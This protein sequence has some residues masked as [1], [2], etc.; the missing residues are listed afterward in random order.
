MFN[1]SSYLDMCLRITRNSFSINAL[2]HLSQLPLVIDYSDETWTMTRK[3]EDNIHLGLQQHGRIC[4][5]DLHAPSSSLRMWLG[6]MNQ[7]F[8]RLIDLCL[9]S[10]TTEGKSLVLPETLQ[11]PDLRYLTLQGI[12][13]P[14]GFPLLSS[15]ITLSTLSLTYIDASSYFSPG[16]LVTHLR[17]QPHLEKLSIGFA[18]PIPCPSSERELLHPP[19]APVTLP[20]LRTLKFRGLGAYLDNLVAQI[21]TPLL[22]RLD[23][24]LFFELAFTLV[25]LTKFIQRTEGFKCLVSQVTFNKGDVSINAG[26]DEQPGIQKFSLRVKC[27]CL[28]WQID[29]ATQVC[30]ALG[31]VVSAAEELTLDLNADG[32]ISNW[33][34]TLDNMMWHELLFPF[35]GVKSLHI[36]SSLTLELSQALGSF[37][38]EL[39]PELLP[40][41][42]QIRVHLSID[43]AK[44]AFSALV[45]TRESVGRPIHLVIEDDR[46]SSVRGTLSGRQA[47]LIQT[48]TGHVSN[49]I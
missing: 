43:D 14:K 23:L 18:V 21:N 7:P 28:D 27:K 39:V 17:G 30:S 49:D 19:I 40:E 36:G 45:G 46:S 1:S 22:E 13:L 16:H 26:Q 44:N 24:T 12:G 4:Q 42:K 2:S 6:Q 34:N 25:N 11:A 41:L 20:S 3:D 37:V 15:A 38:G 31:T 10:T 29:S 35:V 33:E 48:I 9:S 5:V 8:P 32:M 47:I